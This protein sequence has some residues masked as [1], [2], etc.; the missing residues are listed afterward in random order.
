MLWLHPIGA[1]LGAWYTIHKTF[2]GLFFH[3]FCVRYYNFLIKIFH[4]VMTKKS[5]CPASKE[6]HTA[7]YFET[8]PWAVVRGRGVWY[9]WKKH[10]I[11]EYFLSPLHYESS[12]W[13]QR[14]NMCV[15]NLRATIQNCTL[16]KSKKGHLII[17]TVD[18]KISPAICTELSPLW[19][20]FSA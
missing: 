12:M 2:R 15:Q 9:Y 5:Y 8:T 13:T 1:V 6:S 16:I 20:W 14:E 18:Y 11:K 10:V 4:C 7:L 3:S 19:F 17:F